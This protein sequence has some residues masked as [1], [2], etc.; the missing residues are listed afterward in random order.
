MWYLLL[1]LLFLLAILTLFAKSERQN[2]LVY[3]RK[4]TGI[5]LSAPSAKLDK[6]LME[7]G[8]RDRR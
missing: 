5:A 7:N 4:P 1:S 8:G 3:P 6:A 2:S